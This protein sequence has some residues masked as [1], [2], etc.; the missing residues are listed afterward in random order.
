MHKA[1]RLFERQTAQKKIVDQT[2]DRGVQA[3]AESER[4]H[5]QESKAGRFDQLPES[6]AKIVHI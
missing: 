4:K 6:E 5:R 3:D 1:L 2:E